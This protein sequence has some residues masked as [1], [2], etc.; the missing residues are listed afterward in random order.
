MK[1]LERT[2]FL[3]TLTGYA[4][5]A[6]QGSGRLVL[7]SG[8]SGMGKTALVE[9]FQQQLDQARWLWGACDGLLTPRPLGP[10]FDIG[11]QAGGELAVLCRQG[12]AR[13]QLFTAFLAELGAPGPLTVV[14][15]E[16]LHWADEA[17]TDL[18]SY[19]GRRLARIPALILAT[20]RD[21]EIAADHPLRTVLGDLATQRCTRRMGLPPLSLAAVAAL[22]ADHE[23]AAAHEMDAA[24]L[25]RIT[26]GNPFYV[27][28]ILEAGWPPIPPTVRDAVGA[29]LAR[30][31]PSAR[32]V[33]ETASVVRGRVELALLT[34][35]MSGVGS[36]ADID[37]SLDTGLLVADGQDVRFRHELVRLA[38][39]ASIPPHRTAELHKRLLTALEDRG[40]ADPAVL[41]HH[42][43]GAGDTAAV[44][45]HAPEAARRSAALGSHR[46]AAAQF[47][48]ALRSAPGGDR[49][50][51]AV[52]HEG[53]A[54]EYGFLDRW[55]E[56]ERELRTALALHRELGDLEA[57]GRI[58]RL[59]STTLWRL[60]RGAE[61]DQ[62]SAEAL[63]VLETVPPGAELA[64]AYAS[65]GADHVISGRLDEAEKVLVLARDLTGRLG[66]T[67]AACYTLNVTGHLLMAQGQD[68]R[69]PLQQ[70]LDLALAAG[71]PESAARAYMGL[72]EFSVRLGEFGAAER[73][74][75]EAL[76]Y[77]EDL[78]LG[79]FKACLLG[80]RCWA[81][82]AQDQWDEAEQIARQ[83]LAWPNLSP[84]NSLNPLRVLGLIRGRGS[85]DQG[86]WE[87]LDKAL[88]LATALG[89]ADML[90]PVHTARAEL[91][92]LAGRPGRAAGEAATALD[93]AAGRVD[94]WTT[95]T[96]AIWLL[97]LGASA[98]LPAAPPG[99]LP[100]PVTREAAGDWKGAADA[101]AALGRPYD[102][103]LARLFSGDETGLREAHSTFESLGARAT[104]A[105]ARRRMRE[106][107]LRAI[108]RGPRRSTR[109][110]PA[111]LTAR[112]Q[113]VLVL[114]SEGLAD[115]EI[116]ERTVNHH[117][118]SVLA[119]I[120]VSSR[121][122]AAR[123][124]ARMGLEPAD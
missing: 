19:L 40:G 118:S 111:G 35:A 89:E 49:A 45:R 21:E 6:R 28:E 104:A 8:E 105:V 41:A 16:D 115:R 97:R 75:A 1:L 76:P 4:Q 90:V 33:A 113:E 24:E 122:A 22:A 9:A 47:E 39:E 103:A 101:W 73:T 36:P 13:D 44:G 114:V 107:G 25:H 56:N 119:K 2:G 58:L 50:A 12:A 68:G 84:V 100:E 53:L 96:A 32:Q 38:V 43:E 3:D 67:G 20:Y 27:S 74:F 10:L 23:T 31:T 62:A 79:V 61:S 17:T 86:A 83:S 108:P 7:V 5:D 64:W 123:E 85:D 66:D 14:V 91:H 81:L 78:E 94:P 88:T 26:G 116:S 109:S 46:E 52:L 99:G 71:Q 98:A 42:A 93:R 63:A 65:R 87:L 34:A 18:L 112:E 110:G 59:L 30:A 117:V 51:L 121:T 70:A 124:A 82:L 69:E 72:H 102:A 15:I 95:G 60:C 54:G 92:W 120:G 57:A 48:R 11:P 37:E 55:E 80:W 29:R 77:A 106:L